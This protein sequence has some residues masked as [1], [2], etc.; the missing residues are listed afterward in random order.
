[1]KIVGVIPA[2]YESS[3]M[4]GKPLVDICGK[5]MIWWVYNTVKSIEE[6]SEVVVATDDE[7][8]KNT[9]ESLGINAI[10]TGNHTTHVARIHEVSEKIKADFYLV[11]CG[12]EPLLESTQI[13]RAL[14]SN[15]DL[16]SPFYVG[17]LCRFFK[18]PAEVIDPA[19]IKIV[20]NN[21]DE[22]IMLS[23]SVIPFPYKTVLFNY[24]KVVGVEC[25]NKSALDF[26]V[27]TPKGFLESIEDVTLQ[28]FLENK[29]HVK[30]RLI[31]GESLSVDTP[32][33]VEKVVKIMKGRLKNEKH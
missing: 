27:K 18:D 22:C 13:E 14:P 26:F 32:R 9:C 19:N 4:P 10:M 7:R 17:G 3:R 15:S 31:E 20:T 6:L 23:R 1:M 16:N 2:R 5:P 33:D 24:K 11:V 25:Y 12:D 29:I 8:I 28:R 30:Y 21:N